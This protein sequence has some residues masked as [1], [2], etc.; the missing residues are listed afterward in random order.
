PDGASSGASGGAGGA[1]DGGSGGAPDGVA[2]G[3]SGD[4]SGGE[5]ASL[6][7]AALPGALAAAW[8]AAAGHG[9]PDPHLWH[10]GDVHQ[11]VRVHPLGRPLPGGPV[12]GG[13]GHLT[14]A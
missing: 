12:G 4:A 2:S 6:V 1:P 9:G 14:A 10:W 5:R 3:A 11:A 8:A 7:L 13:A